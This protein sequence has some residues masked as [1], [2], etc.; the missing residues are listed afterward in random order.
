MIESWEEFV[1]NVKEWATARNLINGSTV[2]A[3]GLKGLSEVGELADN[4]AKGKD[5]RD[6]IGD[7]CVV[8]VICGLQL[9]HTPKQPVV[10]KSVW[11]NQQECISEIAREF[12]YVVSDGFEPTEVGHAAITL[13]EYHGI[14]FLECLNQAWNDIKD[15]KGIMH[16]GVFIKESDPRYK[17]LTGGS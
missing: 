16:N 11:G 13:C 14:G 4:F 6:D 5:I 7:C 9:G 2:Q 12:A 8:A 15:R 17:E 3:Q 10:E 1:Q